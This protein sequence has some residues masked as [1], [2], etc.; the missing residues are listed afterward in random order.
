MNVFYDPYTTSIH[1]LGQPIQTPPVLSVDDKGQITIN[2]STGDQDNLTPDPNPSSPVTFNYVASLTE[3]L[4]PVMGVTKFQ[5]Q[6][7]W[8]QEYAGGKRVL[9]P[10]T[11]FNKTLYFSTFLQSITSACND[12]GTSSVIGLDYIQP[13]TPGTP[14][15]GGKVVL[16]QTDYP[17]AVISGVGLRQRPSCS[18]A[19]SSA[20]ASAADAFL[21]YGNITTVSTTKVGQFELVIQ[22]GGKKAS[23]GSSTGGGSGT[24]TDA[25]SNTPATDTKALPALNVPVRL[26]SWAPII[27]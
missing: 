16:A 9:G 27:E 2:F 1:P 6:L 12:I 17:N 13:V 20:S 7:N 23:G 11:L 18:S 5:S 14:T 21:G 3:T 15:S 19:A 10:M 25:T 4:V 8:R 22:L 26:D 24:G